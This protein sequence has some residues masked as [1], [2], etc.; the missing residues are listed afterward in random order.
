MDLIGLHSHIGTFILDPDAHGNAARKLARFANEIRAAHG[1]KPLL[2][3]SGRRLRL[4]QHP[5]GEVSPRR[6]GEPTL[7]P[8]RRRHLRRPRDL[9]YREHE[10]PTL[11]LETGRA[12]IDE[13]GYLVTSV[14]AHKRL[15][16][17]SAAWCSTRG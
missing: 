8:L 6:A 3:R 9:A 15:P 13:A 5:Q 14:Q 16:D 4:A 12:L 17:G 7:L 2:H 11:V 10:L 1:I